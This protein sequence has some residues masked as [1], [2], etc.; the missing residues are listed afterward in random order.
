MNIPH[1]PRPDSEETPIVITEKS[2]PHI[3][4]FFTMLARYKKSI[5]LIVAIFGFLFL[6]V[7]FIMPFTFSGLSTLVPPE[8]QSGGNQLLSFLSGSSALD[9][10]KGAENPALDMFKNILDSRTVSQEIARD[11]RIKGYFS[12]W[13]TSQIGIGFAVHDCLTSE[14]LRNG[15]FN[16]QVDIKTHWFPTATEKDSARSLVPYLAKLFVEHLDHYNRERLMTSARNTRIF[17]EGEYK[18][19]LVQLDTA[20]RQLQAFQ[21]SHKTIS[22]T[23]QLSAT[24]TSAAMLASQV[25]QLEM[26]LGV[27]ERELSG[28]SGRVELMRAQLEE[29]KR[30]LKKY[31][32]GG[33]GDYVVALNSVPELSRNLAGLLREVKMLETISAYLRQQLETERINEQRNLPTLNVLDPAVIPDRKSSP[34]RLTML[35]IGLFSGLVVSV[36]FVSWKKYKEN[37]RSNPEEHTKYNTFVGHLKKK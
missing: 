23:E 20:Y 11:P 35:L 14:A 29:A 13:D 15:M 33:V 16:V 19:R 32:E 24:V 31:D 18:T 12:S 26:Q 21:E 2:D 25:Q 37:V 7:T 28:N 6:A 30:Q 17:V 10:M 36:L 4:D 22:L 1:S 5:V 9:L 34:R 8:K 27:E 3:L